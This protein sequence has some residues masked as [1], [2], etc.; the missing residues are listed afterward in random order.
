MPQLGETVT[1]GTIVH[2]TV[3]PGDN[4]ALDDVLFEVS[5]DKVD[6]EVPSAHVGVVRELLVTEGDTVAIGTPLAVITAT[7]DE[8]YTVPGTAA[9][10]APAPAPAAAPTPDR[11]PTTTVTQRPPV[12][13]G[14]GFLSPVVR[15]LLDEHGLDPGTVVGSGDGGRITRADVL[16]AAVNRAAPTTPAA[17]TPTSNGQ[18]A[19]APAPTPEVG[20]DDDV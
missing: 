7:A 16:A 17:A 20:P 14:S 8:P 12:R 1:E 4:I 19:L 15:R 9:S 2:W 6:T 18:T 3:S 10:A 11:A 5:T 13:G